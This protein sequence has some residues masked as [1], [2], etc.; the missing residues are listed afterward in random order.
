MDF[1]TLSA[2]TACPLS[3]PD[4]VP[5]SGS[6]SADIMF[7]AEAPGEQEMYDHTPLVGRS[8]KRFDLLLEK[9]L[10]LK[11]EQVYTTNVLKHRPPD[12][13]NPKKDEIEACSHFLWEEIDTVK[14]R[15]IV[16]MGSFALRFFYPGLKISKEH[17]RP[18][19]GEKG[20][21]LEGVIIVPWYH[22]AAGLRSGKMFA[23]GVDDAAT[24]WERIEKLGVKE[25][26]DYRLANDADTGGLALDNLGGTL[27]FDVETTAWTDGKV[28]RFGEIVGYSVSAEPLSALYCGEPPDLVRL[29]LEDGHTRIICHN[30]KF[31]YKRLRENGIELHYFEDTKGLAY[32]LGKDS[33]H[34]K[35]LASSELGLHPT[36]YSEVAADNAANADEQRDAMIDNYEYG[37]ADADN[38]RRLY[39]KLKREAEAEGVLH[40]YEDI[41]R[42][43]I[44]VL[45]RMEERGI[46]VDTKRA[47]RLSVELSAKRSEALA[48]ARE[49]MG[50]IN[51]N[52]S[53]QKSA[54]LEAL[55]AP[56]TKRTEAKKNLIINEDTLSRIRDWNPVL[57]DALIDAQKYGRLGTF[58]DS[59]VDLRYEDGRLHP[60]FNQFG[61][62]EESSDTAAESPATGRL[63]ASSPNI[64]QIPHRLYKG[65]DWG[66]QIRSCLL[67][68]EVRDDEWLYLKVDFAQQEARIIAK[69]SGD[70]QLQEDFKDGL[71]VYRPAAEVMYEKDTVST[72]ER[73]YGKQAFL[74]WA[75]G[76]GSP[77]IR[78]ID[79]SIGSVGAKAVVNYLRAR[80]PN[81]AKYAKS[82]Q[83][84]VKE[85]GYVETLFG[86][87]R[88]IPEVF[89]NDKKLIAKAYRLAANTPIQGTGADVMKIMLVRVDVRLD[90]Q[91][92]QLIN[93]VHDELGL[94]VKRGYLEEAIAIIEE[95][96]AGVIEGIVLPV[97]AEH[98][99]SWGEVR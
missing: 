5:G 97:E 45:A 18:R 19:V 6:L 46:G 10:G 1:P 61:H 15:I 36:E 35:D 80:Y 3:G 21:R 24:F 23:A 12:N 30:A 22:P 34:L 81:L 88:W 49:F 57:V 48:V 93:T 78:S 27:G 29:A 87:K 54:A 75:Y 73:Y 28:R 90:D 42:P 25:T 13:R 62:Y 69:V 9:Y 66:D 85:H 86:R 37:A 94:R 84:F 79:Q 26:Y 67:P 11:R 95:E 8:G 41:E 32:V 68:G 65:E 16:V 82:Q 50:D 20:H 58:A 53:D 89:S 59:L 55:G 83:A 92:A 76:A 72:E 31:E 71:D 77:K 43:L 52:S 17:G 91:Q 64:Q 33:T 70:T 96:A 74:A 63:S 47:K 40:V 51:F 60:N 56:L 44:P 14:P 4:A 2:C 7:V 98:G 38:T 99:A 39:F